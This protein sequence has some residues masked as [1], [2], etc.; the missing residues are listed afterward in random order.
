MDNAPNALASP[1]HYCTLQPPYNCSPEPTG[2]D[3]HQLILAQ[4]RQLIRNFSDQA[5]AY[6][7]RQHLIY[8]IHFLQT[9]F[10]IKNFKTQNKNTAITALTA[11][12]EPAIFKSS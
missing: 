8:F 4:L 12:L 2:G 11:L 7:P 9:P 6:L 10:L 5:T 3:Q 1:P